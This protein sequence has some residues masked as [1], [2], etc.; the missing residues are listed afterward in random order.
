MGVYHVYSNKSPMFKIGLAPAGHWFSLYV[1]IKK[2]LLL[3]KKLWRAGVY[4]FSM[5]KS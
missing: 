3:I 5:K 2:N 4:I 1:Y